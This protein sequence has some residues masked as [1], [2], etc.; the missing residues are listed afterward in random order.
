MAC[1]ILEYISSESVKYKNSTG[2]ISEGGGRTLEGTGQLSHCQ[3]V[4]AEP[5]V[6]IRSVYCHKCGFIIIIIIVVVVFQ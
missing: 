2:R 3:P 6:R 1:V 4:R 5:W